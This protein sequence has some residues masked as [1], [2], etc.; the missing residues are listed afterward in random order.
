MLPVFALMPLVLPVTKGR[1]GSIE[2]SP[3]RALAQKRKGKTMKIGDSVI[4]KQS[5]EYHPRGLRSQ[6]GKT[7][8]VV[9]FAPYT[10][11][12]F[13]AIGGEKYLIDPKY[14]EIAQTEDKEAQ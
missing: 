14:L 11:Y 7:G 4:Y 6:V 8:V 13:V 9:G 10:G 5:S 1:R 2:V 3:R 12:P